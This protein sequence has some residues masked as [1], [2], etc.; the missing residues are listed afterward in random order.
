M[1]GGAHN[2]CEKTGMMRN[3]SMEEGGSG[4]CSDEQL[5]RDCHLDWTAKQGRILTANG[6][7]NEYYCQERGFPYQEEELPHYYLMQETHPFKGYY[8][9]LVAL[10]SVEPG[11][12]PTL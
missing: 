4:V 9:D 2:V 6:R 7:A 1:C 10:V 3:E 8:D 5:L 12:E 11:F